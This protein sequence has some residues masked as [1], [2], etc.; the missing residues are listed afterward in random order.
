[1]GTQMFKSHA[2]S[3]V[4]YVYPTNVVKT[5][6]LIR[7]SVFDYLLSFGHSSDTLHFDVLKYDKGKPYIEGLDDVFVSVTHSGEYCIIAVASCQI[8]ADLQSH[9]R[10]KFETESEALERYLKLAKRFFH[11][12]EYEYVKRD[13]LNRFFDV[14]CAKESFVKYTGE[15]IDDTF[16]TYSGLSDNGNNTCYHWGKLG[17]FFNIIDFRS[18]YTLCLC[19][20][21]P[22]TV[23]FIYNEI[24]TE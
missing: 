12:D 11:P 9:D 6:E 24:V 18:S 16:W 19:S 13:P 10:L 8:G 2:C 22:V 21:E 7:R 3:S 1:M 17:V 4:L 23:K 14:W 15:G 20:T 5:D